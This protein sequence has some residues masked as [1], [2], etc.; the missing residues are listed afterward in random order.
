MYTPNKN[1]QLWIFRSTVK[2]FKAVAN[3]NDIA[4]HIRGTD[5]S[6]SEEEEFIEFGMDGPLITQ[7]GTLTF[8]PDIF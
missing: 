5:R 7:A 8:L 2:Y 1:W 3:N 6:T 4:F